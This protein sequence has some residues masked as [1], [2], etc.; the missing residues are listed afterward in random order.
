MNRICEILGISKP[1]VQAPMLWLT[2]PELAAAVS[3]AGGLGTLGVGAGSD[4]PQATREQANAD[5]RD[6]IRRTRELTDAPFGVNIMTAD[7]DPNGHTAEIVQMMVEE[8]ADVAVLVGNIFTE[9]DFAPLKE[10]GIKVIARPLNPTTAVAQRIEELGADII[11]ATGCDE[12]GVMP[13]GSTGTMAAV[14]LYADAVNIPVL[15]AGGIIDERFARASAILGAEGAFAGT[16]FILSQECRAAAATKE[17]LLA[18]P[19]DDFL[20]IT[21]WGGGAKWRS[22]PGAAARAAAVANTQG[23][24]NPDQ[25]DYRASELLGDIDAGVN[26]G[27]SVVSLIREISPCSD[28]VAELARG[29]E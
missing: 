2:S 24:L 25:G 10:R 23:N 21:V 27:S 1:V 26:S 19:Q 18:T 14:A 28:I 16:R 12:G 7:S 8:G 9:S 29:Y 20:T 22:T 4:A 11:V 6:A 13:A 15:A 17:N 5:F 3:N